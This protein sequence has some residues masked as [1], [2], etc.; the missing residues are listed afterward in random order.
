M[1]KDWKVETLRSPKQVFGKIKKLSEPVCIVVL[2]AD[3]EHK[4]MVFDVF[5]RQFEESVEV[6][7]MNVDM[8]DE[9]LVEFFG[10]FFAARQSLIVKLVGH[11]S[12]EVRGR[13]RFME[14]LRKAGVASLVG[15]YAKVEQH[16]HAYNEPG[17]IAISNQV[18]FLTAAPPS[19]E[20][21]D[22]LIT[23]KD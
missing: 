11:I 7:N 23:V 16:H 9:A 20:D 2:G 10:R 13:R 17:R 5:R 18:A 14:N 8:T 22:Y 1:A 21:F 3:C 15:V 6:V 19:P 12:C 4:E